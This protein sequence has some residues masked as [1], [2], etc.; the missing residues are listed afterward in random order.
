MFYLL[1]I[2]FHEDLDRPLNVYSVLPAL[3]MWYYPQVPPLMVYAATRAIDTY[4]RSEY[5]TLKEVL[6]PIF[7]YS[8]SSLFWGTLFDFRGTSLSLEPLYGPVSRWPAALLPIFPG[9][10]LR[11]IRERPNS[12]NGFVP[13]NKQGILMAIFSHACVAALPPFIHWPIWAAY[14]SP[15]L[16]YP[17]MFVEWVCCMLV[18]IITETSPLASYAIWLLVNQ[19]RHAN[20]WFHNSGGGPSVILERERRG[21]TWYI[22]T[23][24]FTQLLINE[25]GPAI[26]E[27][28]F[29]TLPPKIWIPLALIVVI[30]MYLLKYG[31]LLRIYKY[32]H[33]PLPR[34]KSLRLLRLR[35]QPCLPNSPV[36]CDMIHTNLRRPP[37]YVAVSH[38]WD[39]L[40]APQ[41]MI[42]I[43]GGLF[44][45]SRS[46]HK[47]LL[48]K[49]HNLHPRYFWIDSICINQEDKGEKSR[50]VGLIRHIF[51]EAESTLC[52]LGDAPHAKEAF[53]LIYQI[54]RTNT[55]ERFSKLCN[56]SKPGWEELKKLVSN[57]FFNRVWIVQEISVSK[58]QVLRYG[59]HEIDW[60]DLSQALICIMLH[61][62]NTDRTL[63]GLLDRQEIV[64][65]LVMDE[66]RSHVNKVALI[67]LK[68]ALKLGLRFKATLPIDKV[69]ALL[70]LVDERHTPLLHPKFEASTTSA[71]RP[72]VMSANNLAKDA[73]DI[74]GLLAEIL[75]AAR[76]ATNSRR[77][78]AIMSLGVQN[79]LR[80]TLIL[81]RDLGT[82][83]DRLDQLNKG[84]NVDEGL[85][86]IL[87][88]YS[89]NSSAAL[90][91]THVARDLVRQGDALSFIAHAGLGRARNYEL[92]GLPS[93]VPDWSTEIS[94][95][96]LP[97]R[98]LD[99]LST[100]ALKETK[101]ES[102]S[103]PKPDPVF[104][105]SGTKCLLVK[106]LN[107][108]RIAH[109]AV[110]TQDLVESGDAT[111]SESPQDGTERD[112]L[113]HS[114]RFH[115]AW[116]LAQK[117]A[118][119]HYRTQ[120]HTL[121][122][123]FFRTLTADSM[124]AD[125]KPLL[126]ERILE[127]IAG[128]DI[129]NALT[130]S[131]W[132]DKHKSYRTSRSPSPEH[133][134]PDESKDI[135]NQ[136]L[137]ARRMSSSS[138]SK[139]AH[140]VHE[141]IIPSLAQYR[142][143]IRVYP[144]SKSK[145]EKSDPSQPATKEEETPQP[146]SLFHP[147]SSKNLLASY[148]KYADLTIGRS[149]IIT[150]GGLM[151]LASCA[152]RA[153][154]LVVQVQ[155]RRRVVWLTL[156]EEQT[157]EP[158]ESENQIVSGEAGVG[159]SKAKGEQ[160]KAPLP[161]FPGTF[162][163]IGEAYVDRGKSEETNDVSMEWFKLC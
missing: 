126:T 71:K 76:G 73:S 119:P 99:E 140:L 82:I 13:E 59:E 124:S 65:A 116:D 137:S 109:T 69:Y 157:A 43:D 9:M 85:D 38:R 83:T 114:S 141:D 45:V 162:Q 117:H 152:S 120:I 12:I 2:Q 56:E 161:V 48:A 149:F 14:S 63:D 57:D 17:S 142:H 72:D 64:N 139:F 94:I 90:V 3:A 6:V 93:W 66:V 89:A 7:A 23:T 52:W 160:K 129:A 49:R 112:F 41:E 44:P 163:L 61:G 104:Q 118:S 50:Q 105:V 115:T 19:Y 5:K 10:F 127:W 134:D 133:S 81:T 46:L 67:K 158:G 34:G 32:Q 121:E 107:L 25:A 78:R 132:P 30:G 102:A 125:K 35:A 20:T 36:Q 128:R 87:P 54:N 29:L 62:F 75:G 11:S 58:S 24:T 101:S 92:V 97:R 27:S 144:K 4:R 86:P 77:A 148:A 143:N 147:D 91:Y 153:G 159:D 88:D 74:L 123:A 18:W 108:G 22:V 55:I 21:T 15:S 100:V 146:P 96:V 40:G 135:F 136:Y 1:M 31:L 42:L 80:Y 130:A 70:G 53:E 95:Y 8:V 131:L 156:R 37:Q 26:S 33:K 113:L 106:A 47:L 110:L 68:D 51:E 122:E 150:D 84:G 79:A 111:T 16:E 145:Q 151:G 98:K 103:I 28:E 39:A 60:Q 155:W 138:N 154:D